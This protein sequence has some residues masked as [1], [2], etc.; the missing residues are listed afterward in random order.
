MSIIL[1]N[2]IECGDYIDCD[3]LLK[4]LLAELQCGTDM[5]V[6]EALKS[7]I[8]KDGDGNIYLDLPISISAN[9]FVAKS[10]EPVLAEDSTWD[11]IRT[12]AT[13]IK[14]SGANPPTETA[15]RGSSVLAF[16]TNA[17]KTIYFI[18]QMPHSWKIGSEVRF[19][20]HWTIPVS[21]AGAGAENVKWNFT[22]SWASIGG[23]FP[24][25]TPETVTHDVQDTLLNTHIIT[26]VVNIPGAGHGLSSML[27][28]SLTRDVSVAND[29]G[30][31]AYITEVDLHYQMDTFG[32]TNELTK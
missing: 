3:T 30:S 9:S 10:E 31:S 5:T 16:P 24:A 29:Y 25:E 17:N 22:Y 6:C 11:D 21:G 26:P 20:I 28:C 18:F 15:Y 32:S 23:T 27:L 12:P 1:S 2:Y 4:L 19:H 7:A 14:L 13:A 8:K